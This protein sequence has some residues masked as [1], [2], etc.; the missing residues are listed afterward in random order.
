MVEERCQPVEHTFTA[1]AWS[2]SESI[3]DTGLCSDRVEG[4]THLAGQEVGLLLYSGL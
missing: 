2:L 1:A 3:V 4:T